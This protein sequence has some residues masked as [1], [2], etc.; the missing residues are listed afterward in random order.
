MKHTALD[1]YDDMPYAMYKYISQNGFHFNKKACSYAVS[2]MKRKNPNSN[3]LEPIEAWTKEQVE[4]LLLRNGVT[5]TD[6]IM[7]DHVYVA[8]MAKADYYKSSLPDE[9]HMALFVKDTLEDVDGSDEL[10]F[11][12]WLQRCIAMGEPVEFEDLL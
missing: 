4:D 2:R 7:Y 8:N 3:K 11:R 9:A 12:Y 5:L 1:V 6:S 10:P